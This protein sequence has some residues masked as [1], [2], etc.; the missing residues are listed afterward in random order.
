MS[1]NTNKQSDLRNKKK[2][3]SR[4]LPGYDSARLGHCSGNHLSNKP[5]LQISLA[6]TGCPLHYGRHIHTVQALKCNPITAHAEPHQTL[7]GTAFRCQHFVFTVQPWPIESSTPKVLK[8]PKYLV[9]PSSHLFSYLSSSTR[10]FPNQFSSPDELITPSSFN[11]SFALILLP[12]N[13]QHSL[14]SEITALS[15]Y[16][17]GGVRVVQLRLVFVAFLGIH[18]SHR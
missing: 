17:V 4:Q 14:G 16:L 7:S 8:V 18:T 11:L 10:S 1:P 9:S 2:N 3:N 5:L 13:S 15:I 6:T 12:T